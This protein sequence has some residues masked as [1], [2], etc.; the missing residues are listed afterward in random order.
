MTEAP[1]ADGFRPT[2]SRPRRSFLRKTA[3]VLGLL[4]LAIAALELTLWALGNFVSLGI[5]RRS[6]AKAEDGSTYTVISVGDSWT[7]GAPSGRYPEMLEAKLNQRSDR[8]RFRVVNLGRAGTNSSQALRGLLRDLD[9]YQPDMLLVMTG[10][11]DHWNLT[12]STYWRFQGR[13]LGSGAVLA[14]R[15]RIFLHSL[16]LYKLANALKQKLLG[17]PTANEFFFVDS[18]DTSSNRDELLA[19]DRET[20]RRQLEFNLTKFVELARRENF[21]LVF[22]TYFHFHGYHVNEIIRDV[23]SDHDVALADNTLAFH[24]VEPISEREGLRISDGH[25][26]PAG[27]DFIANNVM[28]TLDERTMIP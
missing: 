22:L 17:R 1:D 10:N 11:N 26:S 13:E 6:V 27:Y 16:R 8:I 2:T 3:R 15:C 9:Q 23:A 21:E 28:R 25:P 12:S 24:S 18:E 7:Q 19:I 5:E 14:A 4:L 20:H